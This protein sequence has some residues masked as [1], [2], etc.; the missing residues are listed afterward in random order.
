MARWSIDGTLR[1]T[2][3]VHR[4]ATVNFWFELRAL[5]QGILD[6]GSRFWTSLIPMFSVLEIRDRQ[7][8][9]IRTL[10]LPTRHACRKVGTTARAQDSPKFHVKFFGRFPVFWVFL[11]QLAELIK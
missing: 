3:Y 7:T 11:A 10:V 9:Q 4:A 8:G 1:H 6:P 2:G 5:P